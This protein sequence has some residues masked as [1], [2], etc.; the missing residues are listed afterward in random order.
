MSKAVEH[1][2]EAV[3]KHPVHSKQGH[4]AMCRRCDTILSFYKLLDKCDGCGAPISERAVQEKIREDNEHRR[5]QYIRELPSSS[6]YRGSP[7]KNVYES[8]I[9][10]N[11]AR[12]ETIKVETRKRKSVHLRM[13][14]IKKQK[15]EGGAQEEEEEKKKE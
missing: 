13:E 10:K 6:A 4:Q 1:H 5:L 15:K 3:F 14:E 11:H 9:E 8:F 7:S 12:N 2:Q